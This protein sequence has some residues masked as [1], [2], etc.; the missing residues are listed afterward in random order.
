MKT[1]ITKRQIFFT[2]FIWPLAQAFDLRYY[3]V[4]LSG[5]DVFG[6][7]TMLKA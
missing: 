1:A 2:C 7:T 4:A 5:L 3:D 6:S